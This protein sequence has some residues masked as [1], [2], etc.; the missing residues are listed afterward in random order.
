MEIGSMK[1]RN[2]ETNCRWLKGAKN[3]KKI[4]IHLNIFI[5]LYHDRLPNT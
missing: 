4:K 2:L 3:S 5:A 1:K